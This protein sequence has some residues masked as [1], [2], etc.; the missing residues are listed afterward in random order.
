MNKLLFTIPLILLLIPF[1]NAEKITIDVPF[2]SHGYSCTITDN[3]DDLIY[4]CVFEGMVRTL[5][6]EELMEFESVLTEEEI[7]EALEEIKQEELRK[8]KLEKESKKT[9]EEQ[10]LERLQGKLERGFISNDEIIHLKMLQELDKCYQGLGKSRQIQEYREFNIS[11]YQSHDLKNHD[12]K[13]G[14]FGKLVMAIEECKAQT[15]LENNVLSAKYDNLLGSEIKQLH[16]RDFVGDVQAIPYD[17]FRETNKGYDL[18]SICNL[19]NI[20]ESHKKYL[21]CVIQYD[22]Q[23]MREIKMENEDTFG[24]DGLIHYESKIL[25]KY[26]KFKE[27]QDFRE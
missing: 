3:P 12:F 6:A 24:T 21:G 15:I 19:T 2:D 16:H 27:T 25:E 20:T 8:I 22:G 9:F 4:T 11:S 5:T 13:K 18:N 23:S 17:K 7:N 10:L 1:A 14:Y 26:N